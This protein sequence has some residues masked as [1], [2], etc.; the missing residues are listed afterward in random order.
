MYFTLNDFLTILLKINK[1]MLV[2]K[3]DIP[4]TVLDT[5]EYKCEKKIIY[6]FNFC[7]RDLNLFLWKVTTLHICRAKCDYPLH[8]KYTTLWHAFI[9]FFINIKQFT[10]IILFTW[11]TDLNYKSANWSKYQTNDKYVIHVRLEENS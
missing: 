11:W 8:V 1:I 5:K 2:F 3:H 9:F 6:F 4:I 10:V 7:D